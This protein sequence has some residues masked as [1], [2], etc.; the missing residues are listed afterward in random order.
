MS[1]CVA[2]ASVIARWDEVEGLESLRVDCTV[3]TSS[4]ISDW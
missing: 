4:V 2:R 3:A 1:P